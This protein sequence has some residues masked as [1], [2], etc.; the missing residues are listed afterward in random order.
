MQFRFF[1]IS[2]IIVNCLLLF[3]A[4]QQPN[5]DQSNETITYS[6]DNI[7]NSVIAPPS[8][9]LPNNVNPPQNAPNLDINN[10]WAPEPD[11]EII[12]NEEFVEPKLNEKPKK[13]VMLEDYGQTDA[14]LPFWTEEEAENQA[15]IE[16]TP[17]RKREIDP[18]KRNDLMEISRILGAMHA[19][20]IACEGEGDQT[21]RSRMNSLLDIEAPSD[22]FIRDPLII[23]FNSGFQSHNGGNIDCPKNKEV[24]EV[25]LA[26]KGRILSLKMADFYNDKQK[27]VNNKK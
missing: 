11:S 24:T 23:S 16:K 27:P 21:Y 15:I 18:L 19:L 1:T 13:K 3:T 26:Q 6:V 5:N 12:N 4:M 22:I 17:H 7:E 20:R 8:P 2:F 10:D 25:A 9:D 14:Q